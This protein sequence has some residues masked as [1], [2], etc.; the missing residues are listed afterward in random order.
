MVSTPH[1][2]CAADEEP[3]MTQPL[4]DEHEDEQGSHG[5]LRPPLPS[6]QQRQVIVYQPV[7]L[8]SFLYSIFLCWQ[9]VIGAWHACRPVCPTWDL[10]GSC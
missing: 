3:G 6:Y 8:Q 7:N 9:Q 1:N 5:E 10:L 2:P 4:L